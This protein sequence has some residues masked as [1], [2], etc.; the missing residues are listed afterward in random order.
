MHR[1]H[2][3]I[4]VKMISIFSLWYHAYRNEEVRLVQI[5]VA[6]LRMS[7]VRVQYCMGPQLIE[8]PR[9]PLKSRSELINWEDCV[10]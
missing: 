7:Q 2:I 10:K 4:F 3:L 6:I 8:L 1:A 5:L 9:L